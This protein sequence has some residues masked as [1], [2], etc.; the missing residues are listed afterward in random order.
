MLLQSRKFW[1]YLLLTSSTLFHDVIMKDTTTGHTQCLVTTLCSSRTV[2]RHTAPR[3]A[4]ATVE[5]LRQ[6]TPDFLASNLWPPNR[7]ESCGLRDVGCHAASCLPQTKSIVWINW[8]GGSL[9]SGAVLNSRF[10]MSLLTSGEEDIQRV[11]MLKDVISNT[12]C[13]LTNDNVD[14]VHICYIQCDWFDCYIFNY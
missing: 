14:F 13:E 9:V 6:K 11:S 8:K 3:R 12:A 4:R 7:P 5:M 2:H 1:W 10:L